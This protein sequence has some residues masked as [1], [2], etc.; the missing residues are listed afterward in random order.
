MSRQN[1]IT[2]S[3]Q[4]GETNNDMQTEKV[5]KGHQMNLFRLPN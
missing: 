2:T 5:G 3:L 1:W 4:Q